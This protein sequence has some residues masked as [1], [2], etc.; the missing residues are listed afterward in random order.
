MLIE[1][2]GAD[3]R[4]EQLM[5]RFQ[6]LGHGHGP[7]GHEVARN[8]HSQTGELLG[9]AVER[10]GVEELGGN[11]LGQEARRSDALGDDLRRHRRA[12]RLH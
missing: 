2:A 10:H 12:T 9:L 4:M 3:L 6:R 1:V 8:V 7:P 5:E 11:D